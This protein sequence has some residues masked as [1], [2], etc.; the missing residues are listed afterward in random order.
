MA[1]I[2]HFREETSV[3]GIRLYFLP[4]DPA[5]PRRS[6]RPARLIGEFRNQEDADTA[7]NIVGACDCEG[8]Q[9]F[10]AEPD[11]EG[12]DTCPKCG[13]EIEALRID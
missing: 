5:N 1:K 6:G 9:V 8:G 12:Y 3:N 10:Y 13:D 2:K 4:D 11:S 7:R